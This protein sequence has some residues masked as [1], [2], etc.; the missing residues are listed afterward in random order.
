MGSYVANAV[1]QSV[2]NAPVQL[3]LTIMFAGNV[4]KKEGRH[5][6]LFRN[7]ITK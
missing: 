4:Q 2:G 6:N 3:V 5:S 1:R 7:S